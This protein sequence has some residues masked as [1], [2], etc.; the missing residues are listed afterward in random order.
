MKECTLEE[1]EDESALLCDSHREASQPDAL[2]CGSSFCH[3]WY[4]L[5]ASIKKVRGWL[6]DPDTVGVVLFRN[7]DM[8]A[9]HCGASSN[10]RVGTTCTYKT[11]E[12]C[13]NRH[14]NDLPSQ[15]QYATA[16]VRRKDAIRRI[17]ET[18]V[19]QEVHDHRQ[20]GG[21]VEQGPS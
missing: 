8:W 5:C 17:D 12:E 21:S 18:Q 1:F 7:E 4:G 10:M 3:G 11:I 6:V 13:E 20:G 14:I 9:L 16:Y 19:G 15:R 2:K